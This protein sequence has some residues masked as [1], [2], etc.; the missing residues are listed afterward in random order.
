MPSL[1]GVCVIINDLDSLRDLFKLYPKM[2]QTL[3]DAID[4]DIRQCL[5]V[6]EFQFKKKHVIFLHLL[7]LGLRGT[8]GV[9]TDQTQQVTDAILREQDK[10]GILTVLETFA[11]DEKGIL[12]WMRGIFRSSTGEEGLWLG[13]SKQASLISDLKFLSDL[14][15]IPINNY[16]DE[17]AMDMKETAYKIL[18]KQVNSLVMQET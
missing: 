5:T 15:T 10:R 1:F 14:R 16:L 9:S 8:M 17:A 11:K 7:H 2:Q 13:A 3:I 12:S 18:T 6:S 4:T